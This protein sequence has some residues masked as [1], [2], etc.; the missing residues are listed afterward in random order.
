MNLN[1]LPPEIQVR[2]GSA[3][4]DT[5]ASASSLGFMNIMLMK[6]RRAVSWHYEQIEWQFE[7]PS[8]HAQ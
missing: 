6:K 5:T 4:S 2:H 7:L 8:V 1:S 3:D